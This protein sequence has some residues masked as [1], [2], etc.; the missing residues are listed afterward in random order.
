MRPS[1]KVIASFF[2]AL[3]TLFPVSALAAGPTILDTLPVTG[4]DEQATATT[5]TTSYTVPAG[6]S[7]K[8]FILMLDLAN[9]YAGLAVSLNG[10]T[11]TMTKAIGTGHFSD[12]YIGMLAA[13]TSGTLSVHTTSNLLGGFF[14]FTVQDA[15]QVSTPDDMQITASGAAAT[16][17]STNVTTSV[18]ND[19]LL[20]YVGAQGASNSISYGAGETATVSPFN[21]PLAILNLAEGGAQK[22]AASGAGTET[23]TANTSLPAFID[24]A[25][26]A[27]KYQAPASNST[28]NDASSWFSIL[29]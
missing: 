4:H 14:W 1:F 29:N 13:P 20:S 7:N 3:L 28:N 18:G 17:V 6:G 8:V 16:T 12:Q 27:I 10:V 25:V 22:A 11:V 2:T 15:A 26:A 24:L 19:L 9:S 21:S 23:M 5:F